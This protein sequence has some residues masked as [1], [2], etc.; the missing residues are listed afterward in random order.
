MIEHHYLEEGSRIIGTDLLM[1]TMFSNK[2]QGKR[3]W[4]PERTFILRCTSLK[5][6]HVFFK[7]GNISLMKKTFIKIEILI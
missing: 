4:N 6:Q 2:Q 5:V 3:F 1:K 7:L